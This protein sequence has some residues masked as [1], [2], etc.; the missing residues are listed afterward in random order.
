MGAVTRWLSY[1]GTLVVFVLVVFLGAYFFWALQEEID[2]AKKFDARRAY[3]LCVERNKSR[4]E[5]R[6]SLIRALKDG[7]RD[8]AEA[9]LAAS[10]PEERAERQRRID[11]Y[12]ARRTRSYRP[13]QEALGPSDC[14]P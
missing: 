9:S 2:R 7:D 13:I 10:P 1:Y 12:L 5:L 3:E 8:L 6:E 4:A 14:T 11:D